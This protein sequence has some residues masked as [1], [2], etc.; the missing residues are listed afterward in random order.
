MVKGFYGS[1][2]E[3]LRLSILAL[4]VSGS[5][6]PGWGLGSQGLGFWANGFS[7]LEV[8]GLKAL[9]LGSSDQTGP[10]IWRHPGVECGVCLPSAQ[11]LRTG[12]W[13]LVTGWGEVQVPRLT[14]RS[15]PLPASRAWA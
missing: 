5:E 13:V 2:S 15:W 4:G 11:S 6:G 7:G 8:P 10:W 9:G 12:Y 1:Q 14:H 3:V